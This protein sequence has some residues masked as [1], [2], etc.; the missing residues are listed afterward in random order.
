MQMFA[1]GDIPADC[2]EL[3]QRVEE[4]DEQNA[5][6][7]EQQEQG[8]AVL[9]PNRKFFGAVELI[10][11]ALKGSEPRELPPLETIAD[12]HEQKVGHDQIAKI[13]GFFDHN[14][15]PM[16]GLVKREL[17]KPGCVLD[18][19][20]SVDGRD[21]RDPRLADIEIS[22]EPAIRRQAKSEAKRKKSADDE[23]P[24]PETAETL[25]EQGVTCDQAAKMLKIKPEA[26]K[27][28]FDGFDKA[29]EA[30]META[31]A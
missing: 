28:M 30:S 13:Y 9:M 26:V 15:E 8:D 17:A 2:R 18:T 5:D 23:K 19:P 4:F 1:E 25:W 6:F 27:A 20:G 7:D 12:L 31:D 14:G 11:K 21:W 24:C 3:N 29:L 16:V 10:A 22:E